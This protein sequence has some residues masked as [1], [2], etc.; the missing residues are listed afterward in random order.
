MLRCM[1]RPL[2]EEGAQGQGMMECL[3]PASENLPAGGEESRVDSIQEKYEFERNVEWVP[4]RLSF[5]AR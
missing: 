4:K 5:W 2:L 3:H 1:E